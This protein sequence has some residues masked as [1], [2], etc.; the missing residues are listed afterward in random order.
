MRQTNPKP[1]RTRQIKLSGI[2]VSPGIGIGPIHEAVE[3]Q[4]TIT[5]QKISAVDIAAETARLEEAVAQSRKQLTKLRGKLAAL[6]EDSQTEIGPLIDAYLLMLGTSRLMRGIR[7]RVAD[8]LNTAE[9]A[10]LDESEAQAAAI[11]AVPDDDNASRARRA[12]EVLEI[13]RRLLRNLTRQPFR[14]FANLPQGAVLMA[15]T[16]RPADAAL[17]DP[18]RFAGI[19]TA[20]GGSDG[21]TAVMLRALGIPAL[22]G[23]HGLLEAARAGATAIVD[24]QSGTLTLNPT[25]RSLGHATQSL[26]EFARGQRELA[27]LRRLASV[28][29]DHVAIDLQAN[30]ELPFELPMIAQSGATGIGLMR[31]EFMFMNRETLPDE[32]AQ[33]EL[34]RTV[35]EAMDGEPVTIRVLDWGSEKEIEAM[36]A[37]GFAPDTSEINP[38]LGLR[39][40]R[41]LLRHPQLLRTQLAAILRAGAAGPVRVLLPMISTTAELAKVRAIYLESWDDLHE[42]GM[43]MADQLPP[44]GIMIETPAAALGA[45]HLARFAEFFAIGTNDLTMYTLA[46]DRSLSA[47]TGLY[48]P[49]DPT[50]L[51]LIHLTVTAANIGHIPVSICGELAGRPLVAPLL[52]G[53]G[54]RQFSMHGAAIP[55]VKKAIR[56]VSIDGCIRLANLALEAES[57]AHVHALIEQHS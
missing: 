51:R 38:A 20:E 35:V 37:A 6:P 46:A 33:A 4:L 13:G 57:A 44:L 12:E 27:R 40:I 47:S 17:I 8:T 32:D 45:Q 11:L 31:T 21:H 23:V 30:L 19:V 42:R 48:D 14:S 39:G 34:Y 25:E 5:R 56:A 10:V 24:A 36:A 15:E 29:R 52:A 28:T 49:L 26:T 53:L 18:A 50:V 1:G 7:R 3:P 54:L 55:R 22:L 16:L 43:R 9:A 41:V 2:A